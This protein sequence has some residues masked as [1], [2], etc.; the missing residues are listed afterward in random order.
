MAAG[1]AP[2]KTTARKATPAAAGPTPTGPSSGKR[3]TW[4]V[5]VVL[6]GDMEEKIKSYMA[7]RGLNQSDALRE[8]LEYGSTQAARYTGAKAVTS[9][10]P[11]TT[12]RSA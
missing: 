8:F 4:Q 11:K 2:K 6:T 1:T 12:K 3:Y 5:T 9:T 10:S 7:A